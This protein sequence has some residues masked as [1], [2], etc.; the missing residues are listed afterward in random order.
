M[1]HRKRPRSI[2][3]PV[4]AALLFA[5]AALP[6]APA[7]AQDAR[8]ASVSVGDD[9]V[10]AL[11]EQGRAYCFGNNHSAQLGARTP[12]RCGIVDESGGRSCYPTPSEQIPLRAGGGRRFTALSAGRYASCGV[13]DGQRAWCWGYPVGDPAAYRDAC[14]RGRVC[15]FSPVPLLPERRVAAVAMQP[16]C[17]VDT[18]GAAFCLGQGFRTGG[19]PLAPWPGTS[20]AQ[21]DGWKLRETL[22]AV[23]QDGRAW[24]QGDAVFGV[25]GTGSRDS[26]SAGQPVHG[27]I[28]FSQVAVLANWVCGLA[29]E[30]AAYCWGSAGYGDVARDSAPGTQFEVCERWKTRTWCNTRPAPVQGGLRFAT[31]AAMPRGSMPLLYEMVGITPDGAAYVWTGRREPSP[32]HPE[33]RWRSVAAGDWGQCGVTVEGEL[34]CWGRDPHEEVQGLVPHPDAGGASG[35]S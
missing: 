19:P 28:R 9:H 11:D 23:G 30:G 3:W 27:S 18:A 14:L 31:L 24:C 1:P 35:G 6:V 29:V 25:L 34:H 32:W 20:V 16:R 4:A 15:S 12:E 13:D 8:W 10:C 21:M 2:R 5:V 33:H 22:C 17:V 26:A 7:A